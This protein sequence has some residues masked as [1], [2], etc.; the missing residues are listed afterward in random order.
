MLQYAL[1]T[2]N[3]L[4][5]NFLNNPTNFSIVKLG[6]FWQRH[7]KGIKISLNQDVPCAGWCRR[8]PISESLNPKMAAQW[9][10]HNCMSLPSTHTKLSPASISGRRWM[11]ITRRKVSDWC[12]SVA[13]QKRGAE[14]ESSAHA[15]RIL[16][17][18]DFFL[19]AHFAKETRC[20]TEYVIHES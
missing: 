5:I 14:N 4:K 12:I 10:S 8:K 16:T 7:R 18:P 6:R 15:A 3:K 20:V 17:A 9:A 13:L 11:T 2:W 1:I 19:S